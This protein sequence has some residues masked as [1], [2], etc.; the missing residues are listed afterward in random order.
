MQRQD[1]SSL[2]RELLGTTDAGDDLPATPE[3]VALRLFE[4]LVEQCRRLGVALDVLRG[5]WRATIFRAPFAA[6]LGPAVWSV[7]ECGGFML[8]VPNER[9]ARDVAGLLNWCGFARPAG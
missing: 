9:M 7:V 3:P 8:A 6:A 1:V 5:P 2:V 4:R